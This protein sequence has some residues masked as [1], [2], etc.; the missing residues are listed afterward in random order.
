MV[1]AHQYT[2]LMK[3][4]I[5]QMLDLNSLHKK[6]RILCFVQPTVI[7]VFITDNYT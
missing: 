7:Q 1:I 2:F 4:E 6:H 5:Y 3:N